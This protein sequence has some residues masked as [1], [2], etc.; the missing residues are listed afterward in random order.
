[1]VM[2]MLLFSVQLATEINFYFMIFY[3]KFVLILT[4]IMIVM[5]FGVLFQLLLKFT[6]DDRIIAQRDITHVI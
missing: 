6:I 5:C 1:M 2:L 4:S 3:L